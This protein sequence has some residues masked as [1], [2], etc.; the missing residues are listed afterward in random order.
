MLVRLNSRIFFSLAMLHLS[1]SVFAI[2]LGELRGDPVLG[3]PLRIEIDLLGAKQQ[4]LDV[5]CFRLVPPSGSKDIPWLNKANL[6]VST[7]KRPVL[8]VRSDVPLREPILQLVVELGCGYDVV[9][10]YMVLASPEKEVLGP[11]MASPPKS[12]LRHVVQ[13]TS[14]NVSS[15]RG[16]MSAASG[17]EVRQAARIKKKQP[18]IASPK[19]DQVLLSAGGDVGDPFLRMESSLSPVSKQPVVVEA[20]REMLRLEYRMLMLLNEQATSQMATAEKIRGME[21]TLGELQEHTGELVQRI[22]Q[23]KA[24]VSTSAAKAEPQAV[25]VSVVDQ[26]KATSMPPVAETENSFS[27]SEWSLYG[28]L[29][30]ALLGVA[31]WLG[32]RRY[33]EEQ[34]WLVQS[35]D[36]SDLP[37]APVDAQRIEEQDELGGVDLHVEPTAMGSPMQVDFELVGGDSDPDPLLDTP[38]P[39]KAKANQSLMSI[40]AATVD[41]HFEVNP[42]MELAD[43]ML[44][45]GRVKGAAQALQEYIDHSPQEA[46]Q[47]W[48]RLLEV[49]RMADMREEFESLATKLN[50]NFNV[51]I[52]AWGVSPSVPTED[53]I[54]Q[55]GAELGV[56]ASQIASPQSIEEMPRIFSTVCDLWK[57]G[58]VVG[59]LQQLLRDNRGGKRVGFSLSVV[60]EIL[61]L[62]EL[63]E[64]IDRVESGET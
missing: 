17:G 2:G 25:Q 20:Q 29:L 5:A 38:A 61:F 60:E 22:D 1:G 27:F 64:L 11:V 62:V 39:K 47:P 30:G 19:A 44:S 52:P 18:S 63:K 33:R 9:R 56:S 32:W 42:V 15:S 12:S 26:T 31:G 50:Q 16:A 7:G 58:D 40:S 37:D 4:V 54:L 28:I 57:E 23:A 8:Q 3:D 41:E 34:E 13:P 21:T 36:L 53:Q 14:R 55:D 51:A 49:Y 24:P 59:Y 48:I 10:N 46:L 45:F 6:S 43:I 35:G